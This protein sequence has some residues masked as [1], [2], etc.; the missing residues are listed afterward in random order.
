[1]N[2]LH[3]TKFVRLKLSKGTFRPFKGTT[4]T[5]K[6]FTFF[7]FFFLNKTSSEEGFYKTPIK[8]YLLY[9]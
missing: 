8:T 7:F 9:V 4:F 3:M 2:G 1:M 5:I 6:H